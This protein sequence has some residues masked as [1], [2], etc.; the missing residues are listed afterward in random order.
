MTVRSHGLTTIRK[1]FAKGPMRGGARVQ[2]GKGLNEHVFAFPALSCLLALW[3]TIARVANR[4][5]IR[6]LAV[7]GAVGVGINSA[8]AGF[9]QV[10]LTST[11]A[12]TITFNDANLAAGYAIDYGKTTNTL[13][14]VATL[15]SNDPLIIKFT[16]NAP[17]P[18][19]GVGLR[20]NI[21]LNLTDGTDQ[22]WK[23]FKLELMDADTSSGIIPYGKFDPSEFVHP[24]EA[25]FHPKGGNFANFQSYPFNKP[26]AFKTQT[27]FVAEGGALVGKTQP[28]K[29]WTS[30]GF[31]IHEVDVAGLS[32]TFYL[33]ETPIIAAAASPEPSALVMA[34]T[35]VL[36]VGLAYAWRRRRRVQAGIRPVGA[37]GDAG[38]SI[39]PG[40]PRSG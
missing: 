40:D 18:A 10:P 32:R 36:F 19:N 21:N 15:T 4:R 17:A 6:V 3:E 5:L 38:R 8:E 29:A 31:F 25:H 11:P 12:Y 23:G 37:V 14:E 27:M 7:A 13:F 22:N 20:V 1:F 35:S 26:A 39:E 9:V 30:S 28:D 2:L 34:S 24:N 33:V 16:E